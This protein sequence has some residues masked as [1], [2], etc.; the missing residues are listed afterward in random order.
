M[1]ALSTVELSG[2]PLLWIPGL[3]ARLTLKRS[4]RER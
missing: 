3:V 4:A 1:R 2:W